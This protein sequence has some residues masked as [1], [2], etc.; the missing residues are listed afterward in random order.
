MASNDGGACD[1]TEIMGDLTS[2]ADIWS[3]LT[4]VE[5]DCGSGEES[6][7]GRKKLLAQEQRLL[8]IYFG[9][10]SFLFGIFESRSTLVEDVDT[11]IGIPG[12]DT[13]RGYVR[14]C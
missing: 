14:I 1:L 10:G 4:L 5:I 7:C 3:G 8:E 13:P 12:K 9:R 2:V 6:S 11:L